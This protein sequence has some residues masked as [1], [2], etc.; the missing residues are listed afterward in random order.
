MINKGYRRAHSELVELLD[1]RAT[2]VIRTRSGA[3]G[4]AGSLRSALEVAARKSTASD[5]LESI[6]SITR[7]D[8]QHIHVPRRQFRRLFDQLLE[9][10]AVGIEPA[11][12]HGGGGLF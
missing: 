5:P 4:N 3:L 2:W 8:N 9:G 6:T 11:A 10:Q 7:F 12:E 1:T